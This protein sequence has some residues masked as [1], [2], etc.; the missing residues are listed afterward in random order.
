M[1]SLHTR[2]TPSMRLRPLTLALV[3]MLS[4][5]VFAV[6]MF[7]KTTTTPNRA[8]GANVTQTLT[9]TPTA[10]NDAGMMAQAQVETV[11]INGTVTDGDTFSIT[12]PGTAT[13]ITTTVAATDTPASMATELHGLITAHADYLSNTTYQVT[14]N[15]TGT[16]TFTATTPGTSFA[17]SFPTDAGSLA[18]NS[19]T[20]TIDGAET[21]ANVPAV[22]AQSQI[23]TL[24]IGGSVDI[25]DVFSIALPGSGTVSFT[26][27]TTSTADV[28]TGLNAAIQAD[29]GVAYAAQDYTTSVTGSDIVFTAKSAGTGWTLGATGSTNATA[30]AQVDTLTPSS[31]VAGNTFA[32]TLN[33]TTYTFVAT[34]TSATDVV[35]GLIAAIPS[36]T[37]TPTLNTGTLVLTA[38]TPG[39]A[40]TSVAAAVDVATAA[41]STLTVG[42]PSLI[43]AGTTSA[44]LT[45]KDASSTSLFNVS[46]SGATITSNSASCTVGSLTRSTTDG[47]VTATITAV[48][49]GSCIIGATLNGSTA[50]TATQAVT[51][52]A[53]NTTIT[54]GTG[55]IDGTGTVTG[56]ANVTVTAGSTV[57]V[58]ATGA[59]GST[60]TV[61]AST[62]P[63]NLN[64]GGTSST[65]AVST[66]S[67]GGVLSVKPSSSSGQN[68]LA[69]TNGT[70]SLSIGGS[71]SLLA[72]GD[73]S[74]AQVVLTSG[75][76]GASI[77]ASAITG[78]GTTVKVNSGTVTTPRNCGARPTAPVSPPPGSK[79]SAW[80]NYFASVSTYQ[81]ALLSY[82]LCLSDV[83]AVSVRSALTSGRANILSS[84][85]LLLFAG[86]TI[87]YDSEGN[88]QGII[89][90]DGGAGV[91]QTLSAIPAG[92]TLE[93]IPVSIDGTPARLNGSALGSS[94]ITNLSQQLG[95]QLT[96]GS[97]SV[98]GGMTMSAPDGTWI[99]GVPVGSLR[100][101]PGIAS[102]LQSNGL[103][104]VVVKGAMVELA[105]SLVSPSSFATQLMSLD[106]QATGMI[107]A[108]G[109]IKATLGGAKYVA[110]PAWTATPSSLN[111]F[112]YDGAGHLIHGDG[113]M[114]QTLYPA[115]A[116]IDVVAAALSG[117]I[118]ATGPTIGVDGAVT[119]KIGNV[120]YTLRAGYMLI[121]TPEAHATD[122]WWQD[123]NTFYINN[124]DGTAQSFSVE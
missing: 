76:G 17:M 115:F 50:V 51:V 116:N 121:N 86:E 68:V 22:P 73:S 100:V 119:T 55:T 107:T 62:R 58:S 6:P 108:N 8:V 44:I 57:D 98:I 87:T 33:G 66:N 70:M 39:T 89:L 112:S 114:Q 10:L 67:G 21:Q 124:Q 45:L 92:M 120:D 113:S 27:T 12:L 61:D 60:L 16:L 48:S 53:S 40:F 2:P 109:L 64:L 74:P 84:S 93:S 106:S 85:S 75:S 91:A 80:T 118:G 72:V 101:A 26:A 19:S 69:L 123:G 1:R 41:Q 47:T 24:T 99:A 35:N 102:G 94:I 82:S 88:E 32:V 7:S 23:D 71:G 34:T 90:A 59:S 105:P 11:T 43:T 103:M 14:D 13:T 5:S 117:I 37:V 29:P 122:T 49:P 18:T 4:T 30:V 31:I 20:A 111:G 110:R 97:N 83:A 65:I 3:M 25:G 15:T 38:N 96:R 28:A 63:V 46:A 104:R 78:G 56:S 42:T 81:R 54:G 79:S 77:N 52:T 36:T 9:L 95:I